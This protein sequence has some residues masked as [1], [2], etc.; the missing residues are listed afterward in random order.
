MLLRRVLLG[1]TSA[2]V[3]ARAL[4]PA[5]D[6]GLLD[7]ASNPLAL[8]VPL[9]CFLGLFAW[10]MGRAMTGQ[11]VWYSG[12][13]EVGLAGLV[14]VFFLSTVTSASLRH[15]AWLVSWEWAGLFAA[16]FLVRQLAR[17]PAD[18][19]ALLAVLLATGVCLAAQSLAQRLASRPAVAPLGALDAADWPRFRCQALATSGSS[20]QLALGPVLLTALPDGPTAFQRVPLRH[21]TQMETGEPAL[22]AALRPTVPPPPAA[23]FTSVMSLAAFLALLVPPLFGCIVAAW[24]GGAARWRLGVAIG[25]AGLVT[26]A[27]AL[28]G[29]RTALLP[30]LLVGAAAAGLAGR[31]ALTRRTTGGPSPRLLFG[32]GLA[33]LAG[34]LLLAFALPTSEDGAGWRSRFELWHA[35]WNIARSE[36]W[37]GIGPGN[38]ERHYPEQM[39]LSGPGEAAHPASF[40]F[41][42]WAEGGL[43][44]A[45]F[46]VFALL[47]FFLKAL[48]FAPPPSLPPEADDEDEP[49]PRWEYY[50]G[51]FGG[52]IV[53]FALRVAPLPAEAIPGEAVQAGLRA[54]LW[55]GLFALLHDV[56]WG[57][58]TRVLAGTAGVAVLLL[59]LLVSG[60][61]HVPGL[62]QPLLVLMA[63]V[64]NGL[65]ERPRTL[66]G[67]FL[68]RLLPVPLTAALALTFLMQVFDPVTSGA[69]RRRAA[70]VMLQNYFDVRGGVTPAHADASATRIR[71]PGKVLGHVATELTQATRADPLSPRLRVDAANAFGLLNEAFPANPRYLAEAL[72]YARQAQRLDPRGPA[73]YLAESYWLTRAAHPRSGNPEP[74]R[75]GFAEVAATP[76]LTLVQTRPNDAHLRA[77]LVEAL[78]IGNNDTLARL[79]ARKALELDA[80]LPPPYCL[81][82]EE[83]KRVTGLP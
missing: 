19:R 55:F 8:A 79:Q 49:G 7:P 25:S 32:L 59:T 67:G 70:M 71:D 11:T 57:G 13:V 80:V 66:G 63:L 58:A 46:L 40:L 10:A 3:V 16:F 60:S 2:L 42:F 6:P 68:G 33:G 54:L 12:A 74:L 77:R 22:P 44:A 64:L 24:L 48:G 61:L 26:T 23:T 17:R 37:L 20:E 53:G 36:P 1:L 31:H 62:A 52:L 9:F 45:G 27:L 29:E 34:A 28:T 82:D 76:L 72:E 73:G 39:S 35:A 75:Q 38:F 41:E 43:L 81:T 51:G 21:N 50:L 5:D 30:V 69:A 18:G 47:A 14:A 15:A 56:R 78:R 4:L 65:P 83:R